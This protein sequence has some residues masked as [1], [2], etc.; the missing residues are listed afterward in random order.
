[1]LTILPDPMYLIPGEVWYPS[2]PRS[3]KMM[4]INSRVWVAG[5][6]VL[7]S[8]L[9][10]FQSIELPVYESPSRGLLPLEDRG[11]IRER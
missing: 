11:S 6:R 1:M 8:A 5:I 2:I 10:A 4:N 3:C 7:L 9:N